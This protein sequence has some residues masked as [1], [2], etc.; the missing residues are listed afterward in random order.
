MT[1]RFYSFQNFFF[2]FKL[3]LTLSEKYVC[4]IWML[5]VLKDD[6]HM[7][8]PKLLNTLSLNL[9]LTI[10]FNL[11]QIIVCKSRKETRICKTSVAFVVEYD[12]TSINGTVYD[13]V[14]W[15]SFISCLYIMETEMAIFFW[16]CI[17]Y[18]KKITSQSRR[19]NCRF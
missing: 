11:A 16:S 18:V 2:I 12:V 14:L 4:K 6:A 9:T 3:F 10:N 1:K 7:K 17:R 8:K 5:N 19:M 15:W 13:L